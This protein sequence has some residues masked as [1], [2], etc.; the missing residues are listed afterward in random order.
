MNG[1][2]FQAF[3]Y[4]RQFE[5]DLVKHLESFEDSEFA[6]EDTVRHYRS[7][8]SAVKEIREYIQDIMEVEGLQPLDH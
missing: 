7:R 4:V 2:I 8:L 5:N 1:L 3:G 6:H